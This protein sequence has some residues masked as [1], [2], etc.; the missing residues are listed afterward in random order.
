MTRLKDARL[1]LRVRVISRCRWMLADHL[2]TARARG[3]CSLRTGSEAP[4]IGDGAPE[5]EN[6]RRTTTREKVSGGFSSHQHCDA[7]QKKKSER[8]NEKKKNGVAGDCRALFIIDAK[9]VEFFAD[10]NL[11][12]HSSIRF[13]ESINLITQPWS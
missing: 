4:W 10:D 7:G 5:T 3:C 13:T 2:D 9:C 1:R 6:R 8:R 11:T 12:K